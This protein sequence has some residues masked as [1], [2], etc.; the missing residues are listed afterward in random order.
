MIRKVLTFTIAVL[1]IFTAINL[2]QKRKSNYDFQV[3][4]YG[5]LKIHYELNQALTKKNKFGENQ[6]VRRALTKTTDQGG[7]IV[8][9]LI[10]R[11][12]N[13]EWEDTLKILYS[14][15]EN[16]K[17]GK[18]ITQEWI[19]NKWENMMKDSLVYDENFNTIL[20]ISQ[21]WGADWFNWQ[22]DSTIYNSNN[23]VVES[24]TQTWN[25]NAW[26]ND[27]R[28][29]FTYDAHNNQTGY[30]FQIWG[31]TAWTDFMQWVYQ[32]DSK[33]LL[34]KALLKIKMDQDWIDQERITYFYNSKDL[35]SEELHEQYMF[36]SWA[37]TEKW[38][39]T[40]DTNDNKIERVK[41]F[42]QGNDW[43]NLE[44]KTYEYQNGY[45]WVEI[46]QDWSGSDWSNTDREEYTTENNQ[47]TIMLWQKW[48]TNDWVN[49]EK[50][51]NTYGAPVDINNVSRLPEKFYLAQNYPNPFNPTTTIKYS[52][53]T[54][55][56]LAKGRTEEGFVTLK[57]Y[58]VLGREITTL[59]NKKQSPGTYT[60]TF[61][62]RSAAGELPS[63]IY[64]Y[65]L[66]TGNFSETKKMILLR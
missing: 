33:D 64:F 38:T 31:D 61:N 44:R 42:W 43:T 7:G 22:K 27:I 32:Y 4:K 39:Y 3:N 29:T 47:I 62:A 14:F 35:L 50:W 58:D 26:L 45:L 41:E 12:K 21:L 18:F 46:T 54:S 60:V 48:N 13:N 1:F 25:D 20:K 5:K 17:T 9:T 6:R 55:S 63:G 53:A 16:N 59:V 65:R 23:D 37:N 8:E 10:Q 19:N 40:Y 11:W 36:V 34:T 49:Y 2:G 28:S 66:K 56:P 24:I 30:L 51:T 15:D 52:I 57:I